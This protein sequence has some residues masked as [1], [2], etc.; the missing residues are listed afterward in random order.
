[1]GQLKPVIF[2]KRAHIAALN[3]VG[4]Q[5]AY[6]EGWDVL[7]MDALTAQLPPNKTFRGDG[8]HP[9]DTVNLSALNLILNEV[10]QRDRAKW[11][12]THQ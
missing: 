12:T 8:Y 1:M 2:G 3:A 4:R 9:V 10:T 7:D 5:I 11:K 6:E